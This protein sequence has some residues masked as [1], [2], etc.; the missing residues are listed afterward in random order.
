[1]LNEEYTLSN[2]VLEQAGHLLSARWMQGECLTAF[3]HW[4]CSAM[5]SGIGIVPN[6]KLD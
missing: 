2:L 6:G 4:T 5:L 3:A 1:M